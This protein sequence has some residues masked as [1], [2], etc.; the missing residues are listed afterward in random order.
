[1]AR[2]WYA[3]GQPSW[4]QGR[5]R[6]PTKSSQQARKERCKL[7][8]V[9]R[10]H[11]KD[12]DSALRLADTLENC[13]ENHRCVSG[14]CPECARAFQRWFVSAASSVVSRKSHWHVV[15]LVW[16]EHRFAEGKLDSNTMFARLRRHLQAALKAADIRLAIGG[17]DIS[18]NE[19]QDGKFAPH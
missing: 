10:R 9:L 1:M 7:V 12:N 18:M 11:G 6:K 3:D 13:C 8:E 19:H 15:S 5:Q 14:A 2:Q 4:I 16:R 17:F